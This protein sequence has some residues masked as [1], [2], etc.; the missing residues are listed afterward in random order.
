MG[1]GVLWLSCWIEFTVAAQPPLPA[2]QP[3]AELSAAA[4]DYRIE[5]YGA[6]RNNRAEYDLRRKQG[7]MLLTEWQTRGAL[8]DEATVLVR[9]FDEARR[10]SS[11]QQPLPAPPDWNAPSAELLPLPSRPPR[12]LLPPSASSTPLLRA[13]LVTRV[14]VARQVQV[15]ASSAEIM[16]PSQSQEPLE[17]FSA[18]PERLSLGIVLALPDSP[19]ASISTS[20]ILPKSAAV[21]RTNMSIV[22]IA[23]PALET[24][25]MTTEL[26]K[27]DPITTSDTPEETAELNTA[28]LRAR[29][30]GYDK[31][32]RALQSD[33]YSEED[34]TLERADALLTIFH[35]LG[36]ARRDLLLYQAIVPASLRDEL[37][38]LATLDE[39]QK[40]LRQIID[41]AR[42]NAATNQTLSQQQRAAFER[43]W[44]KLLESQK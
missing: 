3:P 21:A 7:E 8:P 16:W 33:L 42:A 9:W 29:I 18:R 17:L 6:F 28:E 44:V 2:Q 19:L 37:N 31:A 32:W 43:A 35:D 30:R 36:Q 39:L 20:M 10:A 26:A 1:L 15:T 13:V 11:R 41:T 23:S 14:R 40:H 5:I 34:L 12:V 4:R 24:V 22:S 38:G 25:A 27:S